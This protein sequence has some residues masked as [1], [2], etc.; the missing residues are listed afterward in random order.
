MAS[1]TNTVSEIQPP[2]FHLESLDCM[3]KMPVV[4]AAYNQGA[5][6]Y[7]KVK[8]KFLHIPHIRNQF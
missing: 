5:S 7:E 4:E 1:E 6:M 8:G 3:M 2:A